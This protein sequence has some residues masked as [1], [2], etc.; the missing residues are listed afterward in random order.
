MS[1]IIGILLIGWVGYLLYFVFDTAV[2]DYVFTGDGWLI[3]MATVS[4][5]FRYM[6]SLAHWIGEGDA[7]YQYSD[8][9]AIPVSEE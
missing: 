8:E 7:Y 3:S 6:S 1:W 5:D 9:D 2:N 4:K